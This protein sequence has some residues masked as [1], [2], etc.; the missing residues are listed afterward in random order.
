ML[1]AAARLIGRQALTAL[2]LSHGHDT[3][4]WWIAGSFVGDAILSGILLRPGP[5]YRK[6]TLSRANGR[7]TTAQ[8]HTTPFVRP[9]RPFLIHRS[10]T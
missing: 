7:V 8:A 6:D 3:A 9:N 1:I 10:Y 5:L 4:F 2:A